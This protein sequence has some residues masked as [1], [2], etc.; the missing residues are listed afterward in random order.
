MQLILDTDPGVDDAIAILLALAAPAETLGLT[1]VGGNVPQA[2]GRRNALALLYA[3]GR[4]GLPVAAGAGR[5]LAGRFRPAVRFH[6]PG[7][8]SVRLPDSPVPPVAAPAVEF[9]NAQL[10]ARPGQITLIALGPLTNLARLQQRHPAALGLARQIVAM[11][12]AVDCPG[13][14]TPYAEFNFHSDPLAAHQV[15]SAGPPLTLADLGAC[16]QVSMERDEALALRAAHPLGRLALRT[17]QN[18]FRRD[19]ERARFEFYDPL[20]VALALEPDIAEYRA[21]AISVD[22]T[23]GER[24]GESTA[25]PPP[26]SGVPGPVSLAARIDAPRFFRLLRETLGWQA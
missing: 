15:L 18:W 5:P 17:L 6:G 11:G 12:G 10:T 7:G 21:A 4:A 24:R 20:A 8:L 1:T 13:N 26:A 9:L 19:P 2:R 22:T 3:A 16:R 23:D 14:V 25:P